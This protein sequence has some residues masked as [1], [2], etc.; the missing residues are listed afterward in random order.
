M[1]RVPDH[2]HC[3]CSPA[4]RTTITRKQRQRLCVPIVRL[5]FCMTIGLASALAII[6][7]VTIFWE[8]RAPTH[9]SCHAKDVNPCKG[10]V[11]YQHHKHY[12]CHSPPLPCLGD[13]TEWLRARKNKGDITDFVVAEDA[14]QLVMSPFLVRVSQR[15][16]IEYRSA[17]FI[18]NRRRIGLPANLL[19]SE[20]PFQLT[21]R[22]RS[23]P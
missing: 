20:P 3:S 17:S 5:C 15:N 16:L 9:Q 4:T 7:R 1:G 22:I 14:K 11:Q 18:T 13:T 6:A 2:C 21:W 8:I 10:C 23:S 19:T 12:R